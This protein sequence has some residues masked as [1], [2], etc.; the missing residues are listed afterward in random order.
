M[1]NLQLIKLLS[2]SKLEK[3]IKLREALGTESYLQ[4]LKKIIEDVP[5][6]DRR[7]IVDLLNAQDQLKED[8][9]ADFSIM[10]LDEYNEQMNEI[11]NQLLEIRK[12]NANWT[13][14]P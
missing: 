7:E 1:T 13:R 4:S 12:R 6:E 10:T 2:K 14:H 9:L 11:N 8:Y 3:I 5:D